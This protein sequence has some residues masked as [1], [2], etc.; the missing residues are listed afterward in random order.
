MRDLFFS[1][2]KE[3]QVDGARRGD[4]AYRDWEERREGGKIVIRQE[5]IS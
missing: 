2:E 4:V 3:K 5:T 1:E